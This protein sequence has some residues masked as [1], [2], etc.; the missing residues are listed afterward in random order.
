MYLDAIGIVT[1]AQGLA[2]L[3]PADALHLPWER[4]SDSWP[5]SPQAIQAEWTRVKSLKALAGHGGG[6]FVAG[7]VLRLTE[8]G[9]ALATS[10]KLAEVEAALV[11]PH[12]FPGFSTAPADAQLALLRMVWAMGPGFADDGKWPMFRAAFIARDW[13]GCAEECRMREEGQPLEFARSN[14]ADR[15]CFENAR[16]V[17]L[18]GID[19]DVVY[20]PR[21]L[22]TET[23]AVA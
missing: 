17:E 10:R 21:E 16:A 13:M 8:G 6:A 5:A 14:D 7:A 18:D 12:R 4:V 1:T 2:L 9:V 19:A 22:L 23:V 3:T 15:V 20:W 11:A